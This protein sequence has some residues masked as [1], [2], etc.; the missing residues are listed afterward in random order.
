M[1]NY[2]VQNIEGLKKQLE[3]AGVTIVDSIT[4]YEYGKFLHIMDEEGN[5]IELW[6]PAVGGGF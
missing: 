2:T 4:E 3:E 1:I 6:E 5:K